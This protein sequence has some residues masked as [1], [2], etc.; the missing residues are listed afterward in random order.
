MG[1]DVNIRIVEENGY[2]KVWFYENTGAAVKTSTPPS[3]AL[4]W[5]EVSQST[6]EVWQL[7]NQTHCDIQWDINPPETPQM[8]TIAWYNEHPKLI[9]NSN[10]EPDMQSYKIW[11]YV[12]GSSMVVATVPHSSSNAT[13]SWVDN[14]VSPAGK[15]DPVY[16]YSY[17]VKV[18]DNSNSESLYS[19]QVSISGTGGIWKK[20]SEEDNEIN[21]T[22]YAL[23]SNYPNPFNPSTQ[24][25]YQIPKDGFVN[26]VIYNSLGQKIAE[27]V[28][29]NKTTGKYSIE[30]NA[31]DLPSGVYIYKLQSGEFCS[32]KKM[33]LAK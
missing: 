28:N 4:G 26:I 10:T 15:F 7:E 18:L 8:L 2:Y 23:N 24:I 22:T 11:K 1:H 30:F 31:N 16:T 29:E 3:T 32:N 9:W 21:I 6:V 20:N 17:K 13:H 5:S 19:N 25:S 33:V 14:S 12:D 27:L